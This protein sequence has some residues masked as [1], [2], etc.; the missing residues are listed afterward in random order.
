M[1]GNCVNNPGNE[2]DRRFEGNGVL[3]PDMLQL[4]E[5]LPDANC[6]D[7]LMQGDSVHNPSNEVDVRLRRIL[8][9][10]LVTVAWMMCPKF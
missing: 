7:G 9:C 8:W 6:I 10:P 3:P 2:V 1:Q 5:R 4:L